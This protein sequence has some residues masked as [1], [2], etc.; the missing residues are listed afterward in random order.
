MTNTPCHLA[1]RLLD[2]DDA[3]GACGQPAR[4]HRAHKS[5]VDAGTARIAGLEAELAVE[6][7]NRAD[8]QKN[9]K[10]IIDSIAQS[11]GCEPK[12]L[13][14]VD[15]VTKIHLE[16][17]RYRDRIADLESTNARLDATCDE[18]RAKLRDRPETGD[19]P[20][21]DAGPVPSEPTF[22]CADCGVPR[23]KEQGETTFTVCDQC[24]NKAHPKLAV[25]TSSPNVSTN[26]V[27]MTR[28]AFDAAI[29]R[30]RKDERD[31]A[32]RALGE[33]R[34]RH[35]LQLSRCVFTK[36]AEERI[37]AA[38]I[39]GARWMKAR[40]A[41][42]A[43]AFGSEEADAIERI[44]VDEMRDGITTPPNPYAAIASALSCEASEEGILGAVAKLEEFKSAL[45]D[46]Q[47]EWEEILSQRDEECAA[48]D[49]IATALG[50]VHEQSMGASHSGTPDELVAAISALKAEVE[51]LRPREVPDD[52]RREIAAW[53]GGRG[54]AAE[55][56]ERIYRWLQS[57]DVPSER[58]SLADVGASPRD[59]TA[60]AIHDRVVPSDGE[61]GAPSGNVPSE[62]QRV[63]PNITLADA[64]AF[65]HLHDV[66]D[67][68]WTSAEFESFCAARDRIISALRA[69]ADSEPAPIESVPRSLVERAK[70]YVSFDG[71]PKTETA[72]SIVRDLANAPIASEWDEAIEAAAKYV[73]AR[74]RD[75]TF[76]RDGVFTPLVS[77]HEVANELRAMKR[78]AK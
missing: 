10:H 77:Q 6:Q 8:Q 40:A 36:D 41:A 69:Y 44:S 57:A 52:I 27:V 37:A 49:A 13:A 5:F 78:G 53:R 62:A 26:G 59:G 17:A 3:C 29:A 58:K 51:S 73:D 55:F 70:A 65:V 45:L 61:I 50:C 43:R 72:W 39:A 31:K 71:A 33:E 22:P 1:L 2:A 12:F 16:N 47:H 32:E 28:E 60:T 34:S 30:A 66:V 54:H 21:V 24:W 38:R 64:A 46:R 42:S 20:K 63:G 25:D 9:F 76:T 75:G 23:T 48:Y 18:L 56:A 15:T 11:V 4:L 35:S 67:R 74:R 19:A 14:I 68:G 7:A